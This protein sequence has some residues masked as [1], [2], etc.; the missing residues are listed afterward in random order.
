MSRSYT[1]SSMFSVFCAARLLIVIAIAFA[2]GAEGAVRYEGARPLRWPSLLMAVSPV[3]TSLCIS[4][5]SLA[6]DRPLC[7]R[8][9]SALSECVIASATS[10]SEN[11]AMM[12]PIGVV[13]SII[14]KPESVSQVLATGCKWGLRMSSYS[15]IYNGAETFLRTLRATDDGYNRI[16][17]SA[18]S[19][20][21]YRIPEGP[22]G[23][24]KGLLT[25]AGFMGLLEGF[26]K[27]SGG[28]QPSYPKP[29]FFRRSIFPKHASRTR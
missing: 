23:V 9:P 24:A 1:K 22:V 28:Q 8:L 11:C 14:N 10:L 18:L 13:G 19:S 7:K 15:A 4:D 25:G 20:A 16:F 5:A 21:L 3:N 27:Y 2:C 12:I 26:R 6:A 29:S 17:G